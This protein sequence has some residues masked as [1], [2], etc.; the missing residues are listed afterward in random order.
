VKQGIT[1]DEIDKSGK[2]FTLKRG[3]KM[4]PLAAE[5]S[6]RWAKAVRPILDEYVKNMK[7]KGLP[8]EAALTYCVN[9]LRD[10]R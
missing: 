5:E 9:Y 3:N 2:A 10:R 6:E 4:I 1:W 7:D 8:G